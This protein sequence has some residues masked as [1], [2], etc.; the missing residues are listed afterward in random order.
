MISGFPEEITKAPKSTIGNRNF[1]KGGLY[2][3]GGRKA[4]ALC[5]LPAMPGRLRRGSLDQP[6][7]VRSA[8]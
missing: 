7:P 5:G 6:I 1:R 4:R 3:N 2:E 8:L